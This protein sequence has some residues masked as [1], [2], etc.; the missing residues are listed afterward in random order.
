MACLLRVLGGALFG[1]AF[2]CRGG[3]EGRL[4]GKSILGESLSGLAWD[5]ARRG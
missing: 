1:Q 4:N 5:C 3:L 2:W